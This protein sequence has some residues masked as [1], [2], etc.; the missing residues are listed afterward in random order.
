M[1]KICLSWA[2]ALAVCMLSAWALAVDGGALVQKNCTKCHDQGRI[3]AAFGVKD[4]AAW[5]A[6]VTRMLAKPN[7]P[8]VSAE[9]QAAIVGWLSAQKK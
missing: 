3:R 4:G 7:A 1:R 5:T 8:A 6:T 9:E 2:G